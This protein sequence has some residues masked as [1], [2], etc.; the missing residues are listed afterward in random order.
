MRPTTPT[1]LLRVREVVGPEL[2]LKAVGMIRT[3]GDAEALVA[4][5]ANRLGVFQAG[6]FAAE[7]V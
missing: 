7:E 2:G 5:G 4:A 3:R 1:D 6:P